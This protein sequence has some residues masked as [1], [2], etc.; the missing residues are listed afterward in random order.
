MKKLNDWIGTLIQTTNPHPGHNI[1]QN[2]AEYIVP[3]VYVSKQAGQWRVSINPENS[4]RLRV[5]D[6]YAN[7]IKR[8][9]SSD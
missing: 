6:Q 3:D 7:L 5:N 1:S 4:P 2:H 8:N 9:D